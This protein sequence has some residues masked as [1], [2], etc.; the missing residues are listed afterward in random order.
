MENRKKIEIE[1]YDKRAEERLEKDKRKNGDFEEFEPFL[2]SSFK[3]VYDFLKDKCAN[4]K[5]L[6][7]GCGDGVHSVWLAELGAELK[8]IDLSENSLQ[9]A[10]ERVGTRN[11]EFLKMDCE[12]MEFS[13]N[14]F[15]IIFDGGTF[16]SLDLNKVFPELA[17]VLKPKGFLIGVETF[18]HN[19][20]TNLKRKINKITK[21]RT[22]WA[23]SHIVKNKDLKMAKEYF[24]KVEVYYFHLISWIAFPF[25]KFFGVKSFLKLLEKIDKLLLY[26]FPFLKNYCFKIVF[27]MSEPK[28][29]F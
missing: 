3:F 23:V 16:S 15:D 10:K 17:R 1:Y 19:P 27:I 5:V 22:G 4:K 21:K 13:D 28:N 24:G 2:L 11:A 12:K 6:D 7:Y 25:L 8:A 29:E 26:I 14:S 9:I 20:F 18:G